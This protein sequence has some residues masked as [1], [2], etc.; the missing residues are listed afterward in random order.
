MF[1]FVFT[2]S[3]TWRN[4]NTNTLFLFLW[5][6]SSSQ[7]IQLHF[8]MSIYIVYTDFI[9]GWK[10]KFY[11]W[12]FKPSLIE[13]N[14]IIEFFFDIKKPWL[15]FNELHTIFYNPST[16]SQFENRYNY[17]RA[18]HSNFNIYTMKC[19]IFSRSLW[20]PFIMIYVCVC[21]A[22]GI[23]VII[24]LNDIIYSWIIFQCGFEW[25]LFYCVIVYEYGWV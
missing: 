12:N 1:L 25:L 14:W 7:M 4:R 20:L 19:I 18:F 6:S 3:R 17:E 15:G 5:Y 11:L 9:V 24:K 2:V 8:F 22:N 21:W 13:L 16:P 23:L 10:K